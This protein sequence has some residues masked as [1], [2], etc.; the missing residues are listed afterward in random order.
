MQR[1][2]STA[3]PDDE[4]ARLVEESS[5]GA[6]GARQLRCRADART[7]DLIRARTYFAGSAAGRAWWEANKH[8]PAS[9]RRKACELARAGDLELSDVLR[10]IADDQQSHRSCGR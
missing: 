9:L 4:V 8:N 7:V 6:A 1:T 5:M 3:L 10:Y 2:L